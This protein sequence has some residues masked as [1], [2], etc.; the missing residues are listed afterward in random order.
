M[1]FFY[2]DAY[3]I[4]LN[5]ITAI[6]TLGSVL[7]ALYF[8]LKE[9]RERKLLLLRDQASKIYASSRSGKDGL[10]VT[11]HNE[12]NLPIHNVFII[13]VLNQSGPSLKEQLKTYNNIKFLE[14][15]YPTE[16]KILMQDRGHSMGGKHDVVIIFFTDAMGTEWSL[17][18]K[19][20]LR[21]V[22]NYEKE[23]INS[24]LEFS[25]PY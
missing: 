23:I 19:F 16:S 13:S 1:N 21:E 10:L 11:L 3:Q 24:Y 25:P 12:S 7:F 14:L 17:D 6:G 15:C 4:I 18:N 20:K 8:S 9:L 22:K 5:S 2:S